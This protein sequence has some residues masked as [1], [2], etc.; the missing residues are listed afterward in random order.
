M[1]D[2]Y[3]ILE[4]EEKASA[5]EIKKSYRTLSKKYHPDVNPEGT[6]QFKEIAE[7]YD[8]LGNTEK[9]GKYDNAKSNPFNGTSYED[10]FSQMFNQGSS[11]FR[12]Q[13]MRKSVPDKIIKVQVSP[14]E[15][16]R[17]EEKTIHYVKDNQ[18]QSCNGSGGEQQTCGTCNGQGFQIRIFGNGFMSQQIR[19]ACQTCAGRGYTLVHRCYHCSG[20]GTKS[21]AN[22]IKVTLPKG[23]DDGQYL[24]IVKSGDYRNGEYGDLILQIQMVPKDGYEKINNDLIYNLFLN[25]EE[26]KSDKFIIPHPDGDLQMASPKLFDTSKPLRLKSK[27]YNGGDMYVKLNVKFERVP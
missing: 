7:A 16:Y 21:T 10:M 24:K 12:Q 1:K 25:L 11:Q 19:Q 26:I 8:V 20:N 27:G 23:V 13:P 6:E 22:E 18:C 9:K 17:G 2:Y 5:E 14:L 4:V 15:S 3:K